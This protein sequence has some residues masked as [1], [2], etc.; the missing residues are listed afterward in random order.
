LEI[1]I[2]YEF[3]NEIVDVHLEKITSVW[4]QNG[5]VSCIS[6]QK[7]SYKRPLAS[8]YIGGHDKQTENDSCTDEPPRKVYKFT[9]KDSYTRYIQIP[10]P[11]PDTLIENFGFVLPKQ[12]VIKNPR[13]FRKIQN[14]SIHSNSKFKVSATEAFW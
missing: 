5:Y 14:E 8:F 3:N 7:L 13:T 2:I 10:N 12:S 1:I 11:R 6:I 4:P 9:C